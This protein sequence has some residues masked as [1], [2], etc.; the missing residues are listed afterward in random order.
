M[1]VRKSRFG[2]RLDP[3]RYHIER[4]QPGVLV[5]EDNTEAIVDKCVVSLHYSPFFHDYF[6]A[7]FS[8]GTIG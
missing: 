1:I 5:E 6:L 7:L 2:T 8:D 4:K 3:D